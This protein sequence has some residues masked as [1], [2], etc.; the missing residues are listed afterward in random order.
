MIC[1]WLRTFQCSSISP[2]LLLLTLLALPLAPADDSV[3]TVDARSV[4]VF[5]TADLPAEFSGI[6]TSSNVSVD[7][8]M[9]QGSA[10][11]INRAAMAGEAMVRGL[12]GSQVAMSI[13]GMKVHSACIDKMDPP[14]AYVELDNLTALQLTA[15]STDLRYGANLGGALSFQMRTPT[16]EQPWQGAAELLGDANDRQRRFRADINQGTEDLAFR[17]GYTYRAADDFLAGGQRTIEGSNF[18]KHNANIG[19]SY[20]TTDEHVLSLQGIYDLATFIGYPALLMD[21]RRAEGV[22][23]A[24]SWYA[25]WD[26][27]TSSTVKLYANHIDHVMDDYDR[28]VEEVSTRPFMP[29]MYMPM[30]GTSTTVGLLAE[31]SHVIDESLLHV[32]L[33]L[34]NL[35]AQATMTMIPLDTAVNEM[36][37]TNIGDAVV[38]TYGLNVSWEGAITTSTSTTLNARLDVSPRTLQDPQARSVLGSYQ[39]NADFDRVMAAFSASALFRFTT[40]ETSSFIFTLSSMERLPNHF[41][42]YGFWLYDPQSNFVV[43]GDPNLESERSYG[44]D[45]SYEIRNEEGMMMMTVFGQAIDD[46]IAT[47]PYEST[48]P[49]EEP[50]PLRLQQNIGWAAIGGAEVRG[51]YTV[52]ELVRLGASVSYVRGYA[53]DQHDNLPLIAPLNIQARTIIGSTQ[54]H[55]EVRLRYAAAQTNASSFIQPENTTPA[56]FT[57]DVVGSWTLNEHFAIRAAVTNILDAYYH[58]HTSINDM[59]SRGR[60]LMLSVRSSW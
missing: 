6:P 7:D 41:E 8:L 15:G 30:D 29:N 5:A 27:F 14:T 16:F 55:A 10:A 36:V 1:P 47:K 48:G 19:V 18:E 56:W 28:S 22:I 54:N 45:L 17:G 3:R 37:M 2:M 59:P 46:Y 33:D 13:D 49:I 20:K 25:P 44:I 50:V 31:V 21:T 60:S 35:W 23:T 51:A 42:S 26:C 39:P 38:G 53:L 32:T 52:S 40:T 11:L 58:E 4:V 12:R 57:V 24:L 9:R 34:S 43:I